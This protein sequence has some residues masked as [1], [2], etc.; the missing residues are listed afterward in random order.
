M[1]YCKD[2]I[3]A[4]VWPA[5]QC[6]TACHADFN[7]GY[8]T[9]TRGGPTG[10]TTTADVCC[11]LAFRIRHMTLAT[12]LCVVEW[13]SRYQPFRGHERTTLAQS[14]E[15]ILERSS[16]QIEIMWCKERLRYEA[17]LKALDEEII[18]LKCLL[19]EAEKND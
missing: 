4:G 17:T 3:E 19:K 15:Q 8:D 14:A 7:E 10:S 11:T 1:L 6:C 18:R 13:K 12:W 5:E 16:D 2:F 9:L